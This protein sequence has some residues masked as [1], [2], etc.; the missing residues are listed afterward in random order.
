M[1][2]NWKFI[3]SV[4]GIILSA[5][6]L[7][8]GGMAAIAASAKAP[9]SYQLSAVPKT[10][11]DAGGNANAETF[12]QHATVIG[13]LVELESNPDLTEPPVSQE[14][15]KAKFSAMY[16]LSMGNQT[17]CVI[18][19]AYLE[20]FWSSNENKEVAHS[21]SISEVLYIIQDSIRIY[22]EYNTVILP[23]FSAKTANAAISNRFPALERQTVHPNPDDRDQAR[24]DVR[25]IILYRLQALSSP[26]AFFTVTE[27]MEYRGN[28]IESIPDICREVFFY[29][30]NYSA[31]TNRNQYLYYRNYKNSRS[32]YGVFCFSYFNRIVLFTRG[33]PETVFPTAEL[34]L[35]VQ[36][37]EV[38][39][40]EMSSSW[41]LNPKYYDKLLG[42]TSLVLD[43][44]EQTFYFTTTGA[45]F[46]SEKNCVVL[47]DN[48]PD[49]K[50]WPGTYKKI[51]NRLYLYPVDIPN[52]VFVFDYSTDGALIFNEAESN[53]IQLTFEDKS[54]YQPF[55]PN[56]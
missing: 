4:T 56:P 15:L 32:N 49:F 42:V 26:K 25:R 51:G 21:L 6:L 12:S 22:N 8:T 10:V 2:N 17:I 37:G 43:A 30:P 9:R 28:S 3:V 44:Q 52:A 47:E 13:D 39:Y 55:N 34:S 40:L 16:D 23:G 48:C 41:I 50:K 19:E 7:L 45:H 33:N 18:S 54:V 46:D 35:E 29:I 27:M 14:E 38:I 11:S 53:Q 24:E 5:I 20:D 36:D 31:D 1:K